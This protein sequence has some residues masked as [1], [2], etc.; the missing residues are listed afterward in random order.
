MS[1]ECLASCQGIYADINGVSMEGEDWDPDMERM[2]AEYWGHK[3]RYGYTSVLGKLAGG[4]CNAPLYSQKSHGI[5]QLQCLMYGR[6]IHELS[7]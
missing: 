6:K 7:R 2:V 4:V 3:D 1:E 5:L